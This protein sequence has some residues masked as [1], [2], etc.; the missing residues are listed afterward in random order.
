M[1][2]N[3]IVH[4]TLKVEEYKGDL[5]TFLEFLHSKFSGIYLLPS[6]GFELYASDDTSSDL[7][8]I[9]TPLADINIFFD[10]ETGSFQTIMW[11]VWTNHSDRVSFDRMLSQVEF[12]ISETNKKLKEIDQ[13]MQSYFDRTID[14]SY[15]NGMEDLE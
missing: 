3:F 10:K 9:K 14:Q 15:K 2:W 12:V 7:V 1:N 13:I 8:I 5:K 4:K 11:G 6:F